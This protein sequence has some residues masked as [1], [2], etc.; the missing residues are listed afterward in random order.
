M[1]LPSA[2]A[3]CLFL[4]MS[5][6][7]A[8]EL[9]SADWRVDVDPATLAAVATPVASSKNSEQLPAITLSKAI[10][11]SEK[12]QVEG[13]QVSEHAASWRLVKDGTTVNAKIADGDFSL[14]FTRSSPGSI[15]WPLVPAAASAMMVPL[16]E[17]SYVPMTD[18]AWKKE[19]VNEYSGINSTQD[20]S[21]PLL[22][23]E[24]GDKTLSMLLLNPYNNK[25]S[26]SAEGK[27]LAVAV[28]HTFTELD[29]ARPYTVLFNLAAADPL[30]PAKRYRVWLQ[31]QGQFVP[32]KSKLA[33][34]P[35]GDKLI[36]A[37][38][39]YLWGTD[40]LALEDVQDWDKLMQQLTSNAPTAIALR[41][42]FDVEAKKA[43]K[44]SDIKRNR[45][46]QGVLIQNVNSA[47]KAISLPKQGFP[48]AQ[49]RQALVALFGASLLP[50][51]EWG[52]GASTKM[53]QRLQAAGLPKL[54]LGLTDWK[55]G[56]NH[57]E[58]IKAAIDAGYLIGPY[59]SYDTALPDS[60]ARTES[61]ST[62]KMGDAVFNKCGILLKNGERKTGFQSAGV[63]TNVACVRAVMEQRVQA[64]Q[65][66]SHYNSWFLDVDATGMVF[67]DYDPTRRTS[68]AQDMANR[69]ANMD[70][71]AHTLKVVLGSEDGNAVG[72]RAVAFAHGM[73][74]KG[75]GWADPDMRKDKKSPYYLGAYFP[76]SQPTYFFKQVPIKDKYRRLFFDPAKRL[77]LYQT[78]FHDSV[79]TTNH[80]ELD[81]LKFKQT[82]TDTVLLQQLYNV[83]PLLS[84]NLATSKARL[85]WLK[86]V[87]TFFRPL[88]QRLAF[89][90]L[91]DFAWLSDD[92]LVQKTRFSDG[93][94]IVANFS[95]RP[96]A[97]QGE[98]IAAHSVMAVTSDGKEPIVTRYQAQE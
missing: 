69:I 56:F 31:Q 62:T 85:N 18:T 25:L 87:D 83:P 76:D 29:A 21:L 65:A 97:W 5:H 33:M 27:G 36:G 47:I 58:A 24:L 22:G 30:A 10:F 39:L 14:T 45:Y 57:P 92:K 17:G 63:Y 52:D 93:T 61:W 95:G 12:N 35:D 1:K 9:S 49:Q 80:W 73:Q 89:Q 70:W 54:W 19:L 71:V 51:A 96:F 41:E 90:A 48:E 20:L 16:F 32:L 60:D 94:E 3:S 77:P 53:V 34:S 64:T 46:L 74:V 81:N 11:Q 44:A 66:R 40:Q 72:A 84:M 91:T 86:P 59:D 38:H 37:S 79:V 68:E 23:F 28:E 4:C 15:T 8:F 26:F 98:V 55:A 67:D 88:H 2:V 50:S 7:N 78:V 6:A 13:L 42:K 43:L 75:F 82:Q